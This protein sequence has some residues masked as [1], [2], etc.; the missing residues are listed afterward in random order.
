MKHTVI[1]THIGEKNVGYVLDDGSKG[2]KVFQ[3]FGRIMEGQ[4]N[5]LVVDGMLDLFRKILTEA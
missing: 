1:T 4:S 3:S 5:K 2:H